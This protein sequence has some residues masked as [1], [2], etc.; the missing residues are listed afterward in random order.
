MHIK[1]DKISLIDWMCCRMKWSDYKVVELEDRII[2]AMQSN[3]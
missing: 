1:E 3:Q 2:E